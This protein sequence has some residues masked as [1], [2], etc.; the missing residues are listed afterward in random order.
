MTRE[1]LRVTRLTRAAAVAISCLFLLVIVGGF[2]DSWRA[3]VQSRSSVSDGKPFVPR[4]DNAIR[5][6]ME[7]LDDPAYFAQT[8]LVESRQDNGVWVVSFT[9]VDASAHKR[10]RKK[11]RISA[12]GQVLGPTYQGE[13][14]G[15]PP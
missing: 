6:A 2:V 13:G 7:A 3:A 5:V 4:Y 1:A 10:D 11:V 14:A 15:K 9:H 8:T 12:N